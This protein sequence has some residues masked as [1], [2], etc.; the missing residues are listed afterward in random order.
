LAKIAGPFG[1]FALGIITVKLSK[2]PLLQ[3]AAEGIE[4]AWFEADACAILA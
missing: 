1:K 2:T 3:R 4:D